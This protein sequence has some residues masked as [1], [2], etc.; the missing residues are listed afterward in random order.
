MQTRQFEG[1]YRN[2]IYSTVI[3]PLRGMDVTGYPGDIG[4]KLFWVNRVL[5][6]NQ[7]QVNVRVGNHVGV[8]APPPSSRVCSMV[9][10]IDA[11]E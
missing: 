2:K 10:M 7:I 8:V 5:G 1:K 3:T 11:W 6:G 4:G 9:E